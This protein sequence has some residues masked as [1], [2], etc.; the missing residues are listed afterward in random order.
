MDASG[1]SA[2]LGRELALAALSRGDKVIATARSSEKLMDLQ[3]S[4][5]ETFSF[6]QLD[7]TETFESLSAKA[8]QA[9][10]VWGQIDVLVNNAGY[11]VIGT[12]EEGGYADFVLLTLTFD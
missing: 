4:Y 12:I 6:L 10:A 1:T 11:S 7:V 8:K 9:V 2:G 5:Q 3:E